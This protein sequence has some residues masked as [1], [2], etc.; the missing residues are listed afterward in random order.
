M[1]VPGTAPSTSYPAA[2]S[3]AA[4]SGTSSSFQWMRRMRRREPTPMILGRCSAPARWRRPG[5]QRVVEVG[6]RAED[7]RPDV[8][9]D[10][11]GHQQGRDRDRDG[12]EGG[13]EELVPLAA[14]AGDQPGGERQEER[15]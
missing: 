8:D 6:E 15:G 1:L 10:R 5:L 7:V 2:S 9:L 13:G 11:G 3:R 14:A 4:R 12:D